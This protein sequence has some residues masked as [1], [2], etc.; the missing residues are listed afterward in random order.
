MD[1]KENEEDAGPIQLIF[2]DGTV[3]EID[4]VPDG[5]S[6]E[7]KWK[8]KE[9]EK[10]SGW[11]KIDLTDKKPFIQLRD[12]KILDYD[13]LLFGTIEGWQESIVIAG[14][15]FQFEN[16]MSLIYY[17]AGDFAKVYINEMPPAFDGQFKLVWK[18]GKFQDIKT[19][20]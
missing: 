4:L 13:E 12:M 11:F 7:Y 3:L 10:E 20:N 16:G 5:E 15:G 6:V 2:T 9:E 17:N 8:I 18:N 14:I 1:G 19:G